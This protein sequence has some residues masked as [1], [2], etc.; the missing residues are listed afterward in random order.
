MRYSVQSIRPDLLPVKGLIDTS[1]L[2]WKGCL[3]TVAFTGGCNFRC[4][5]CHN[6][7][8]VTGCESLADMPVAF[9][10]AHFRHY[11]DWLDR[12]VV[13]GG[14][15]TIHP[16]LGAFLQRMKDAGIKIKLDTNGSNPSV[17]QKLV[18]DGLV[19]FIAMDVKGPLKSY[20]RWCGTKVSGKRIEESIAFIRE[21][22]VDYEFRMT[23][24]PFFHKERDVYEVAEYLRGAKQFHV[25]EFRPARTLNPAFAHIRPFS[26][27]TL[28][29]IRRNVAELSRLDNKPSASN[30]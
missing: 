30:K 18:A 10:L 16:A 3:S 7:D 26:P 14:E 13:T 8:L 12:L 9:I 2:D 15:P 24:V 20:D 25:Q 23:V 17:L 5:F 19:D 21:G 29:R 1:F 22:S 4:P 28:A 6:S 27:D 11:R